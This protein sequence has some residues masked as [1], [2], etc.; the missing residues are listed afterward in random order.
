MSLEYVT[1]NYRKYV[2]YV[3]IGNYYSDTV[4]VKNI[5]SDLFSFIFLLFMFLGEWKLYLENILKDEEINLK[6]KNLKPKKMPVWCW[7]SWFTM[8]ELCLTYFL[9]VT[10]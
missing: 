2:N 3:W 1:V 5:M 9:S 8:I 6:P 7:I 10:L 4:G